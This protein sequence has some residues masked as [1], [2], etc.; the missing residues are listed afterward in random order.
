MVKLAAMRLVEMV[1]SRKVGFSAERIGLDW[2]QWI[3]LGVAVG[4]AL[5][6]FAFAHSERRV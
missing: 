2:I 1:Q 6:C 3:G 5:T 4:F